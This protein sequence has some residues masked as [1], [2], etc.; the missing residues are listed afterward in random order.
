MR[1]REL[2]VAAG[3][4][5]AGGTERLPSREN[6]HGTTRMPYECRTCC[7]V[8]M[9]KSFRNLARPRTLVAEVQR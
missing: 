6:R 9:M 7:C 2:H 1:S 3:R 5:R 8:E 4:S